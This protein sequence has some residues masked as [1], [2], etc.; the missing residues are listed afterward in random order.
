MSANK[1]AQK[2]YEEAVKK[3]YKEPMLFKV[4]KHDLPHVAPCKQ[5]AI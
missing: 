5:A 2:A 4:P 1:S 3:G